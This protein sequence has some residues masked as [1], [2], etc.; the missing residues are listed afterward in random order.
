MKRKVVSIIMCAV[1]ATAAVGCGSS[2]GSGTSDSASSDSASAEETTTVVAESTEAA[3]TETATGT[4]EA[5]ADE[6][7]S[8][9]L[10]IWEHSTSFEP[11]LEGVI[12]GFSA[13]YPNVDVELLAPG[14]KGHF[15]PGE[16]GHL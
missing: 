13:K 2:S 7:V 4:T 9:A 11:S 8:G 12:E 5:T 16:K 3:E 15:L 14:E 1:F 6:N 10:T